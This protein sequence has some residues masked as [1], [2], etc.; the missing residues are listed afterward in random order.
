[1]AQKTKAQL[2]QTLV[3][4]HLVTG[5][6]FADLIDSLKGLQTS[7]SDP[8]SS[9][10]SVSFI[11]NIS[12][13]AEGKITVTKKNVNFSGYQTTSGMLY[14]QS[15]DKQVVGTVVVDGSGASITT[16]VAHNKGHYPT[17][18]LIDANGTEV[19]GTAAIPEPFRVQHVGVNDLVILLSA[20][21]NVSGASFRFI[22]D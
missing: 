6:D 14:Y 22:L 16:A 13:D 3:S 4:G 8:A 2:K 19:R 1:M 21:L 11:S 5:D 10:N 12:Q 9:G 17:V 7:V 15:N 18:R 20:E